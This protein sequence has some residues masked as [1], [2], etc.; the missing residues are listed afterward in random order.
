MWIKICGVRDPDTALAVCRYRPQA[1][2]LNFYAK[3]PR[4]VHPDVA[5]QIIQSLP[6]QIESVGLFVNMPPDQIG[7]CCRKCGIDTAQLHGDE[8]PQEVEQ[9]HRENPDL[10]LIRAFRVGPDNLDEVANWLTESRDREIPLK[11]CLLDARS[12]SAYGGTGQTA[13]WSL[14]NQAYRRD[15]WPPLVLAG[16]L[17]PDNVQSAIRDVQPWGIDVAS[18]VESGPGTKDPL[19]LQRFMQAAHDAELSD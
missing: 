5:Q 2:G 4:H 11:A 6:S 7:V 15:S 1:I 18:G 19:L 13:P 10:N 9:L 12:D 3:S 8:T 14:I 17:T 16:G